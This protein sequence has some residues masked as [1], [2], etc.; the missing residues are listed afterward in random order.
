MQ[1]NDVDT[2]SRD[3]PHKLVVATLVPPM[4]GTFSF[5]VHLSDA[6][7]HSSGLMPT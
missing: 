4:T 1:Q 7:S 6:T 5:Y 3:I 2:F